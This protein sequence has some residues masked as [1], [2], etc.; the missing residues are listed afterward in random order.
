MVLMELEDS[1][2]GATERL[3]QLPRGTHTNLTA[4]L[5]RCRRDLCDDAAASYRASLP[6]VC[7]HGAR[8]PANGSAAATQTSCT[9]VS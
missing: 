5:G 3:S 9:M 4:L 7:N 8:L 6:Q 2:A 1:H